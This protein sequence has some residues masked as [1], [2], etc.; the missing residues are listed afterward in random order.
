MLLSLLFSNPVGFLIIASLLVIALS[1]H[2]F[3][4]AWVADHLGDPTARIAGRLTLNP[5]AHLDPLGTLLLFIAGFGWGKPVPFDPFN[6]KDPKKDAAVI[7]FAGP[8]ANIIM[9]IVASILLRIFVFSP[10]S[11]IQNVLA[12]IIEIF[13]RYNI[14]LAVFNLIPVHPLDG[15][16]VIAG[17]LPHKYYADWMSLA[18]YGMFFLILLIFPFFGSSPI[19]NLISPIINF[20]LSL[21]L[22]GKLGGVI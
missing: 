3:A 21:L 10:F 2:E 17:L 13:I 4:H 1:V 19:M 14:L 6:L 16:K 12:Q 22:P 20:I 15:F 11:A 18:P 5:T 9:A 7:S 8:G